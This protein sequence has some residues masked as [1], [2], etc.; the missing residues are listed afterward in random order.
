MDEKLKWFGL[1]VWLALIALCLWNWFRLKPEPRNTTGEPNEKLHE[2]Q[3]CEHGRA[4]YCARCDM[5]EW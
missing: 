1:F 2:S 5:R 3:Y 4:G